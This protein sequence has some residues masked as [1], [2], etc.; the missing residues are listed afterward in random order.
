[1]SYIECS[2]LTR[3]FQKGETTITPLKELD[4]AIE[5]GTFLALM[6]PVGQRQDDAA[7]FGRGH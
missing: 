7:E 1:M 4:L 6:G 2:K 3:A 5:E